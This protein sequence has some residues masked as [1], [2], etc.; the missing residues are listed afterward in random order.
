[1]AFRSTAQRW[2]FVAWWSAGGVPVRFAAAVSKFDADPG[3]ARRT[4]SGTATL[5]RCCPASF[6]ANVIDLHRKRMQDSF[7]ITFRFAELDEIEA[8]RAIEFE[9]AQRFAGIGMTGIADAQP[10]KADFVRRKIEMS[11][12][13]VAV[14][15]AAR[16]V[17][18]VMFAPLPTRFYIEELDVLTAWAGRRIGAE[19]IEQVNLLARK[20]GARQLVLSTFRDVPWNAPYYRRLGFDVIESGQLDAKLRAIRAAHVAHGLDESKRVFMCREVEGAPE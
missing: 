20:A 11:E 3:N 18:F 2:R 15:E 1:M 12:I 13:I 8:V 9:A 5:G 17:A 19:L 6:D 7:A 4:G 10:M 16:C 14:N